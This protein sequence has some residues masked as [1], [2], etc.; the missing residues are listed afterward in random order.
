MIMAANAV[1]DVGCGTGSL[2]RMAREAGHSGRL[3]GLDPA[4]G[5]LAQ[6][7]TRSDIEWIAGDLASVAFDREFDLVVMTGHVFQ[8]FLTDD[9]V[10]ST[11]ASARSALT[12]NGRFAF[13]SRNPLARAWER[14]TP[15]HGVDF[16]DAAGTPVRWEADV[17]TPVVGDIVRFA[18][19]YSSPTCDR[20]EVSDSTLRFIGAERLLA[21]LTVAGLA[22]EEQ[23]GDW[24]RSPLTET[25][26]EIIT[27]AHRA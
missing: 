21:F 6:A 11:L 15:E 16:T 14:W 3:V 23:F 2:L 13:E 9:H 20:P 27:I 1:L 18:S 4:D 22:I 12:D 8:V 7:R 26:P 24:D 25:S 19:T 10:R 17:E 5:M